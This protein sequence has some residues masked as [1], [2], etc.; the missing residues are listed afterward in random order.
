MS[1]EVLSDY[2]DALLA[3]EAAPIQEYLLR[4]PEQEEELARLL[5]TALL[6]RE[7]VSTIQ[8]NPTTEAQ[9]RARAVEELEKVM[10]DDGQPATPEGAL[11]RAR[12]LLRR[13]RKRP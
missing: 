8:T 2:I 1:T 10:A 5:A 13:L 6:T 9:S 3:G 7:A 11:A 4:H 12:E